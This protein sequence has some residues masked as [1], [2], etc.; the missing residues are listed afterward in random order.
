VAGAAGAVNV[1]L[2]NPVWVVAMQVL[3]NGKSS[4]EKTRK[5]T[6]AQ[7]AA[8][9]YAESGVGGFWKGLVPALAMV[10]NPTLQYVLYEWLTARLMELR[11]RRVAKAR[12]ATSDVFALTALAKCGATLVTYPM[13]LIKSRLQAATR[14]TDAGARYSGVAD[15]TATI[16]RS[17]GFRGFFKGMQIKMIQTVLSAALL[18]SIKE[19][20]YVATR[21]A[22][23]SA[24][25]RAG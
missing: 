19:N 5:L 2:T 14:A 10:V 3:A 12:L 17:E 1:L 15:A 8:R 18:M 24:P 4:D 11:R 22:L 13:L 9:L 23:R 21:A 6:A 25:S 16:L 20:V 7:T